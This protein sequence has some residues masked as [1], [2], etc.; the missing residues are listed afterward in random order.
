VNAPMG[1]K[2]SHMVRKVVTANTEGELFAR[3][4]RRCAICFGLKHDTDTKKG[5]IAHLDHN[6]SNSKL[7]NLVFLCLKHHDQFDSK[8]SQSKGLTKEE[9]K[10][11]R[12]EL[13]DFMTKVR[14][15]NW[16]DHRRIEDVLKETD[17]QQLST[18]V[19]DRRIQ[20][21]RTV[22]D[23]LGAIA[24]KGTVT[25][26]ELNKFSTD[27]DEALFI[28]N[29]NIADYLRELYKKAVTLHITN[30]KLTTQYFAAGEDSSKVAEEDA[31]LLVWFSEQFEV[32]R[33]RFYACI[34]L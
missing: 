32:A 15:T 3:S 24:R 2:R 31:E 27:T 1:R 28:F 20:T 13:Y 16:P 26:D 30:K 34:A 10:R 8:T 25:F 5:Q 18:E 4:R 11:Y 22:R 7:E 29:R 14:G 33:E 9:V 21:Y 12:S 6:S 17:R 23:F 19:Y